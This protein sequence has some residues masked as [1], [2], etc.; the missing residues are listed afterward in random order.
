MD[1]FLYR[2][3]ILRAYHDSRKLY[4]VTREEY[5]QIELDID[6][7]FKY[8]QR[9]QSQ[10]RG[11]K[12]AGL[13]QKELEYLKRQMIEMPPRAVKYARMLIDLEFR[14]HTIAINAQNY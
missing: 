7:T 6:K 2:N 10:Q 3:K 12:G 11:S 14:E 5:K 4:L 13:K 1:L 8:L 9:E